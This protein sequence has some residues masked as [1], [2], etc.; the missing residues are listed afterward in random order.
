MNPVS[1]P[2]RR[3]GR[4]LS[5]AVIA[6]AGAT[7][8]WANSTQ[9]VWSPPG[10]DLPFFPVHAHLLPTG[11]VLMWPGDA[12]INGDAAMVFDPA[13]GALSTVPKAGYDLFCSAHAYL[14][15]GQLLVA[16]GH[17]QNNV[18]VA[19]ATRY[20]SAS[21]TWST[22][23]DMNAGRWYPSVTTLGNGDALVV[24]GDISLTLGVNTLPQVYQAATNSWRS[25][26]TAQLQQPLYPLMFLMPDGRVVDAGPGSTTRVLDT[27]GTGS[28][29][30][31]GTR[32]GGFRDYGTAVMYDGKIFATGGA[33][34]PTS[35]AEVLDLNEPSPVWRS[36]APMA[37]PRRQLNATLL[38]DGKVLV[39]G[40][41][42]GSGFNNPNTPVFAAELWDPVAQAWTT[43]ASAQVPRLY[44]SSA[45]LLPDAS[46]L[47]L[48]GNNYLKPE[49][50]R[51]PYFF[52][53]TRPVITSAP[54][55]IAYAGQFSVQT[56]QAAGI[57]KVTLIRLGSVTH[58]FNMN[59]RLNSLAFTAG[60]DTLTI[61][62]PADSNAAP[63]GD[64]MLFLV[65]ATGVPSVAS[66]VRLSGD[67]P[68][69]PPPPPP[70][71]PPT[72]TA[73][74]PSTA[75][76]GGSGF[77]LQVDGSS[78]VTGAT[79]L[80]NGAGRT[81]TFV[82]ATQLTAQIPGTDLVAAGTANVTAT[83]PGN[84][85]PSNAL[86]FAIAPSHVLTV[87]KT[88]AESNKG[89]VTSS[90]AGISCAKNCSTASAPFAQGSAVTLTA[91]AV[92][93]AR[94]GNWSGACS[95]SATTCTVTMDAA[96][97]VTATFVRR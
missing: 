90:P 56:A 22:A 48:G 26:T 69:P 72:L 31:I 71:A 34:P 78:F 82:S 1:R 55:S 17:I 96:K 88:G 11:K 76:A 4:L 42:S 57:A 67:A 35:R 93:N 75:L 43:M 2:L 8:A 29:T 36:V 53:G 15:D 27:S 84:A 46:V 28:W 83:N 10:Q 24:S 47:T 86:A 6:A 12:G 63:P 39:T 7:A 38:P 32:P 95:G 60:T 40:G 65:D 41:T 77:T 9:G 52:K 79:V 13:T 21:N 70:P 14:A 23:P 50:Y 49:I 30:D 97:S 59:Q 87:N 66:F 85:T 33:D 25:L 18:G 74:T 16:G 3:L 61:T 37:F 81:T 89:T 92:G 54:G 91:K 62:A 94:L 68:P 64:Y 80:W 73:L 51:P 58:A 20:S 44:H 19:K 5:C 45:L